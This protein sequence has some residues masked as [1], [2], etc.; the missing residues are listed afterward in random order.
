MTGVQKV[1]GLMSGTSLDGV[2]AALLET[3]GEDVVR[4]GPGLT[5]AYAPETR[6]LLRAALD[7]ARAVAKGA[8]V[9]QSIREAERLLTEAHAEAVKLLLQKTG[10]AGPQVALLGFHGQTILH[11]PQ[12]HWTWQIGDGALLA[13]LTGIDVVNDFRS[14]DVKAG[15]QGAPL[16][17]LYHA[18]LARRSGR[19]EPLVPSPAS[20]ATSGGGARSSACDAKGGGGIVIV[21]IGGVA[22]VTY[23]KG[24]LVL[25]FDT[26]PGNAPIDDWMHRHTDTPL[27][28][29]GAFAATGKVNG[30]A[31]ETMLA[32]PFFARIPPKS[33]DRMDFGM[34]AVE[35]LSPADGAATLT[36]FTAASL[37]RAREH[38]PDS[39]ETW[40]VSGG[41]RHNRTLMAMLRARVNA[42]V[43][44]AED[45]G[46][47]GDGLEAQGFAYLALRS[48]KGLPLSLP[49]TTGVQQPMTGGRFY[50]AR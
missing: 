23:I 24:D 44:S 27:D 8:P 32:N 9:P 45:A 5:V 10:L 34:E 3:D 18:V 14:A 37:A 47:D 13:R 46:W 4:P 35:A 15:G 33:L 6:A 39:A 49:T 16:M 17:P 20:E 19:P 48:K 43:I 36:A 21:N 42:P 26:G 28:E 50:R 22:Q 41:G 38:F 11:R 29:D 12:R 25:A 30:A 7:D 40:I 31:L 1:I 2:D